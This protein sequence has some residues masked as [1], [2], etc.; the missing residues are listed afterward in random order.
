MSLKISILTIPHSSHRYPTVGDYQ[1]HPDKS[2]S[3]RVS[4]MGNEDYEFLVAIHELIE[5][6]LCLKRFI[7]EEK[8]T[9][10]DVKFEK[11]RQPGDTMEPGDAIGAPYRLEHQFATKIE[12]EIAG[13]LG[14]NWDEYSKV[15][16]SL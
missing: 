2:R 8:I 7:T 15:V 1:D 6:H 14:V 11:N 10:F 9:A 3:V 12:R 13:E 16:D 4:D 5:Q